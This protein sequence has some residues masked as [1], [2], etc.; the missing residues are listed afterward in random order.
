MYHPFLGTLNFK[1]MRNIIFF[2]MIL[3]SISC[4]SEIDIDIKDSESQIVIE[5]NISTF[6]DDSKVKI[7]KTLNLD[8]GLPYP[9][10]NDALVTITNNNTAEV[11]ILSET[12]SG[13]YKNPYL[14]GVDEHNYILDIIIEEE[15]YT[16]SST[17]PKIVVLESLVQIGEVSDSNGGG[18]PG[19]QNRSDRNIAEI[20]P[21][22][23]DPI[24][25]TNYYQFVVTRNDTILS[26]IFIQR[27]YAF[28]GLKNSKSLKI[29]AIKDDI[30]KI[31]MQCIDEA[32]YNYLLGLSKNI[33]QSSATPTNPDSNISNNALGYFKAQTSSKKMIG[34]K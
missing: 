25:F 23:N 24:E 29:E 21:V 27:D 1:K 31:D 26:N 19:G 10:V 30:L 8:D 13:I 12:E 33:H 6:I 7:S 11:F 20:I 22:Y 3:G 14:I 28:N 16:A 32:V 5:A 9:T 17:I 15:T 4:E 2:L 34:I 18:G